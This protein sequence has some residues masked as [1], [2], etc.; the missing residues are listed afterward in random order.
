MAL[1]RRELQPHRRLC[2]P[3]GYRDAMRV[4]AEG[5]A[6]S[7]GGLLPV[8]LAMPLTGGWIGARFHARRT[9][10]PWHPCTHSTGHMRLAVCDD[11]RKTFMLF[12]S[13]FSYYR[14]CQTPPMRFPTQKPYRKTLEQRRNRKKKKKKK[15]NRDKNENEICFL[16][17]LLFKCNWKDRAENKGQGQFM[18]ALPSGVG[19]WLTAA[20]VQHQRRM[21]ESHYARPAK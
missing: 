2:A 1:H 11:A 12:L 14:F 20:T 10:P 3:D 15:K 19:D 13:R 6:M 4:V 16:C 18:A 7:I 9:A 5:G 8:V 17:A 21:R